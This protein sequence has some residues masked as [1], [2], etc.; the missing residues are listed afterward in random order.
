MLHM[1]LSQLFWS[2]LQPSKS[3]FVILQYEMK[4][5]SANIGHI[6]LYFSQLNKG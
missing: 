2:V 5:S 4:L 1:P 6:Y 3:K